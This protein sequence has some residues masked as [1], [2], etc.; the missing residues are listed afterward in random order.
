M[1]QVSTFYGMWTLGVIGFMKSQDIFLLFKMVSLHA[2]EEGFQMGGPVSTPAIGSAP[3]PNV[4]F[5]LNVSGAGHGAFADSKSEAASAGPTEQDQ[6]PDWGVFGSNTAEWGMQSLADWEGWDEPA[7]ETPITSWAECYSLRALSSSLGLS[8]SEVSN[9]IARC[10]EAGL[11]TNDFETSL[12]K[13]NRRALLGIAEHALKYFFPVRLGA[14]VRGIPTGFAAPALSR[15]LKSAGD[16]IPVWPD[17][18]GSERGQAIEPLYKTVPDAV[19]KDRTLYHYL[20]LVDAVRVGGPRESKVA[21][22]LLKAGM[23]L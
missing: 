15:H 17:P 9:S 6:H 7:L 21:I 22:N 12:P 4:G 13:V 20:A 23:G 3:I 8:K 19:K 18:I 1:R 2:Q 16:L 11:L 10:R 5:A 14:I